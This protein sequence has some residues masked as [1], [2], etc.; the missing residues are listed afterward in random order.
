MRSNSHFDM[1]AEAHAAVPALKEAA[2][3]L[4]VTSEDFK[5]MNGP[6]AMKRVVNHAID[7]NEARNVEAIN[8]VRS[9]PADVSK[10]PELTE[11]LGKK[12]PTVGDVDAFRLEANKKLSKSGYYGQSPSQQYSAGPDLAKLETAAGQ[13]R[14]IVYNNVEQ[15]TGVDIRPQKG[16]ESSLIKLNDVTNSTNN[17]LAQQEAKYQNTPTAQRVLGSV[18]RLAAIK[19]NPTNAFEAGM[20]SPTDEFN[21]NMQKV[22]SDVKPAPGS[23]MKNNKLVIPAGQTGPVSFPKNDLNLTPPNTVGPHPLFPEQ[24]MAPGAKQTPLNFS[25]EAH[26]PGPTQL[27][28]SPLERMKQLAAA[29]GEGRT[30]MSTTEFNDALKNNRSMRTPFD[31][32]EGAR[33]TANAPGS[34]AAQR[35]RAAEI[36]KKYPAQSINP[37]RDPF[38]APARA[39]EAPVSHNMIMDAEGKPDRLEIMKGDQPLG[40]LKIEEQIP[41]TW[42]VTDATVNQPGKGYGSGAYKQLISEAQ[43]AGV[44]TI[45]SDI[46]N[47]S[48]AAGVWKSLQREFPKAVTEENGQYSMNVT[49]LKK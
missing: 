33:Q 44:K 11:L 1:P 17:T 37:I 36:A 4:G 9:L 35:G 46:S 26:P 32:T 39:A 40:H 49:G 42:T 5:G 43:K 48:K 18:K 27:P 29:P 47:T 8:P 16:V 21:S 3:D 31:Y 38:A 7:I 6:T 12:N 2:S 34:E 45:E 19:A 24:G 22:F 14:D 13:A 23:V 30:T 20:T 25:P 10:S 41:G 15:H 28:A